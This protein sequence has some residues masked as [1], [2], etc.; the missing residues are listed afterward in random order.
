MRSIRDLRIA[1]GLTQKGLADRLGCT[2]P[3]IAN[4][5]RRRNEPS[6]RQLRGLAGVFG[7]A[8]DEIDFESVKRVKSAPAPVSRPDGGLRPSDLIHRR[9][10]RAA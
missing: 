9:G 1:R 4:W 7:V 8:M 2:V 10:E 6:A 3:T 5:E